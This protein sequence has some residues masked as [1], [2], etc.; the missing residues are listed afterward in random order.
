MTFKPW[1]RLVVPAFALAFA[2]GP[3][4]AF[5]APPAEHHEEATPA[6]ALGYV[7]GA[8]QLE[9]RLLA[10]CCW[11]QTLDIHGSPTASDLKKEIRRR[12]AAGESAD[13][14]EASIVARYGEKIVAVP[15]GSPLGRTASLLAI[16]MGVAGIGALFLLVRWRRRSAAL[17]LAEKKSAAASGGKDRDRYDDQI[18][19]ELEQM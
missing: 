5:A 15:K 11:N 16:A 1:L 14:I 10:P 19:A 2:L 6:E 12:L 13:A 17:A 18:D 4:V 3:S 8:Q 7:P 9:S